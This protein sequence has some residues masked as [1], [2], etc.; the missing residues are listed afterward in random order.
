[1]TS[2]E[3]RTCRRSSTDPSRTVPA[4][5]T[6]LRFGGGL[7]RLG[8]NDIG[9]GLDDNGHRRQGRTV[10]RHAF[11]GGAVL[12]LD[13]VA[14]GVAAPTPAATTAT[15][16]TA[17]FLAGAVG[18]YGVQ[19]FDLGQRD[20]RTLCAIRTFGARLGP[21]GVQRV[22]PDIGIVQRRRAP[23]N[24]GVDVALAILA[25]AA[26]AAATTA[27]AAAV[28]VFLIVRGVVGADRIDGLDV[29]GFFV[30][31]TAATATVAPT[32]PIATAFVTL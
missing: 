25:D 27:T 20:L 31:T 26:T 32:T 7:R 18:R 16:R 5:A 9:A 10:G 14:D 29:G 1:M 3:E 15:P 8:L 19:T 23:A 6:A 24:P 30:A 17:A 12:D 2:A 11:V 28:F 21:S 4:N 22:E 13:L